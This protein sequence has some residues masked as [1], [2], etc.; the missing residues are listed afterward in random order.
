M[1][2]SGEQ[3]HLNIQFHGSAQL[4]LSLDVL[5]QIL[6]FQIRH[7]FYLNSVCFFAAF[8]LNFCLHALFDTEL[9]IQR[10]LVL[11]HSP[12]MLLSLFLLVLQELVVLLYSL[13][14]KVCLNLPFNFASALLVDALLVPRESH[15][16]VPDNLTVSSELVAVIFKLHFAHFCVK[17]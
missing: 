13:F 3:L 6:T 11:F 4:L 8:C 12:H 1:L 15:A 2:F 7:V 10:G 5:L 9:L 16:P 17:F 14:V